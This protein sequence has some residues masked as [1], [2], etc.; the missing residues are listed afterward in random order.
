MGCLISTRL[1]EHVRHTKNSAVEKLAIAEHS[2]LTNHM[3][4]FEDGSVIRL[5]NRYYNRS[6]LE[7]IE[8]NKHKGNINREMATLSTTWYPLLTDLTVR[9]LTDRTSNT[10]SITHIGHGPLTGPPT[11]TSTLS[12]LS[13]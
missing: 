12:S 8:I 4:N 13:H 11:I 2:L 7:A 3:V 10:Y 5:C 6:V 1:Q 9:G